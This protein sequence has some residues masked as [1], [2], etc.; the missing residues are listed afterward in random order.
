MWVFWLFNFLSFI[1]PVGCNH[2]LSNLLSAH[3][4]LTVHLLCVTV[5][6]FIML[7]I[8]GWPRSFF[9][10][11]CMMLQKNPNK[12][13]I[14]TTFLHPERTHIS[15]QYLCYKS[16]FS[17]FFFQS[18]FLSVQNYW[19][20]CS[21]KTLEMY[22]TIIFCDVRSIESLIQY[23]WNIVSVPYISSLLSF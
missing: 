7:V 14:N 10:F 2:Y 1:Y 23:S 3:I 11:F 4:G 18:K 9:E 6:I 22:F 21:E 8:L 12:L 20:M 19:M 17:F 15:F 5:V 16:L 13:L